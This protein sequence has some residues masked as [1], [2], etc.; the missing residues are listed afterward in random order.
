M[1]VDSHCHLDFDVFE[2]D[3]DAVIARARE[4][5]VG[6]LLTICT[7]VT[8]FNDILAIALGGGDD[9]WCSVGIH[10]HHTEEEPET[11]ASELVSR[12]RHPK[13]VGIGE[14]GLDY[15]YDN[16]PKDIQQRSF[17]AHIAAARESGLPLIVHNRESDEDMARILEEEMAKGQFSAVLHCFSSSRTLAETAVDLG[18]YI[19]FSGILTFRNAEEL[20]G[21]AA[22]LPL[23]RLLVETDSPFL[24][25]VPNRG[26]RNEPSF[27]VHTAAELARVRNA[28]MDEITKTTTE[29]FYRLFDR[30]PR[31][32][33]A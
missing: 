7:R 8:R 26:R 18:F 16:S 3:R 29:N 9:I 10:P 1:L 2:D 32:E 6:T 15:H 14:T 17:R 27:V 25:P 5:G 13:V 19:S 20:R 4:A 30:I 21:I 33:A 22:E 24:A 11:A 31:I 12:S 28:R 23:D